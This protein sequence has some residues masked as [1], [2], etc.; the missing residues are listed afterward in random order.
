MANYQ[1]YTARLQVHLQYL[2]PYS[3]L[4]AVALIIGGLSSIMLYKAWQQLQTKPAVTVVEVNPFEAENDQLR[5]LL[6]KREVALSVSRQANEQMQK[7]FAE[8]IGKQ[9]QLAHELGFYRSIMAPENIV[10]GVAIHGVEL[11]QGLL[12]NQYQLKLILTQLSKQKSAIKGHAE[13]VL[14]GI[15][16]SA[17]KRYKLDELIEIKSK[18]SFKYFENIEA[19]FVLPTDFT[20]SKVEI[21]IKVP[22]GRGKK[23][24]MTEQVFNVADILR[25]T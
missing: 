9:Q 1:R 5:K 6:A 19:E 25:N 23:V 8:E 3:W 14:V 15:E 17:A 20:L 18:F 4:F 10:N 16:N 13:I 21:V 12:P 24:G 2:K 7:L 22:A 11:T